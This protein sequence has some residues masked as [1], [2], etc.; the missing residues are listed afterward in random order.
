[1]TT[2]SA[3]KVF[4]VRGMTDEITT[5]ELC[6]RDELRGTVQMIELDADGNPHTDHYFGTSCAA[7]AAGW[8]QREVKERV[9]A[10]VAEKREREAAERRALREA[11]EA[12][13][14]AWLVETYGTSDRGAI[15]KAH[16]FRTF[17]PVLKEWD[18][19]REAAAAA[20]TAAPGWDDQQLTLDGMRPDAQQGALFS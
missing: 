19:Y 4:A 3:H 10:A 1:M 16:G 8:T 5:C 7:K 18:A 11:E 15:M 2:T 12:Q 13:L 20:E 6:G 9:K 14:D 17:V